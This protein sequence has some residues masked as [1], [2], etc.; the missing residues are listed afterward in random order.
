MNIM[1][2]NFDESIKTAEVACDLIDQLDHY[3]KDLSPVNE[4]RI[5]L[6]VI[7]KME[8]TIRNDRKHED[9]KK[10]TQYELPI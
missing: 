3:F 9:K 5:K 7:K 1:T 4:H 2:K 10:F 6:Q 8:W